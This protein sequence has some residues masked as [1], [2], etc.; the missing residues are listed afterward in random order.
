MLGIAGT[1]GTSSKCVPAL[2]PLRL[3]PRSGNVLPDPE[4]FGRPSKVVVS[5]TM[6]VSKVLDGRLFMFEGSDGRLE[7]GRGGVS[8]ASRLSFRKGNVLDRFS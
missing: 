3:V 2:E 5:E 8:T 4:L 1:G 7:S 6:A